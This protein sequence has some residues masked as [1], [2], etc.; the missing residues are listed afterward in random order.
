MQIPRPRPK[1]T[2]NL[3]LNKTPRSS[4][5]MAGTEYLAPEASASTFLSSLSLRVL[6]VRAPARCLYFLLVRLLLAGGWEGTEGKSGPKARGLGCPSWSTRLP[7]RLWGRNPRTAWFGPHGPGCT[8]HTMPEGVMGP[9]SAEGAT[10]CSRCS[11]PVH[12]WPSFSLLRGCHRNQGRGDQALPSEAAPALGFGAFRVA[13]PRGRFTSTLLAG[14]PLLVM[15]QG[16]AH[17]CA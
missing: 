10:S 17:F 12:R 7:Q 9:C 3:S 16:W 2:H 14:P 6:S 13:P 1:P 5:G 8:P 15:A 4:R 11:V